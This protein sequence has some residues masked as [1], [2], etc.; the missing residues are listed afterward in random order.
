MSAAAV[1]VETPALP[2]PGSRL[3]AAA[4]AGSPSRSLPSSFWSPCSSPAGSPGCSRRTSPDHIDLASQWH[5]HGPTLAGTHLF[6]TDDIGRDIFSRTLYGLRTTEEVSLAVAALATLLGI[7][8]AG[9]PAT[10]AAGS[11]RP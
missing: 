5:S 2:L 8:S 7:L 1:E 4:R 10:T 3:L 9:S 11:T 6:G